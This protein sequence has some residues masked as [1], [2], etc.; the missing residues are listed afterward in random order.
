MMPWRQARVQWVHFKRMFAQLT[1]APSQYANKAYGKQVRFLGNGEPQKYMKTAFIA[2]T[3]AL[4][5]LSTGCI[6]THKYVAKTIAP[7]EQR[8]TTTETKNTEQ[9]KTLGEQKA[10]IDNVDRDLSRTKERLGDDEGKITTAQNAANAADAKAASAGSAASAANNAAATADGKATAAANNVDTFKNAV[11][12]DKLKL[13]K[14]DTVLFAFNRRTLSDEAK[15]PLDAVGQSL[16][17]L[18]KYVIEVQGFTDKIGTSSYNDV[19]SGER[20]AAV[21]RYLAN[22]QKVPLHNITMLGSGEAEGDQKT[23]AEREQSRK[24]DIRVFVPEI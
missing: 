2:S 5:F 4:S 15:A 9:D 7:V 19:L 21:A 3:L 12:M 24:V 23:R 1:Q 8:V 11:K 10:Q 17:G 14:N 18:G 16:N 13:V 22:Q 6:A 20:A